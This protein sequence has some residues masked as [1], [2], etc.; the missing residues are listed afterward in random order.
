MSQELRYPSDTLHCQKDGDSTE[1]LTLR[2]TKR[3]SSY[4]DYDWTVLEVI[5]K[6][7]VTTE[8]YVVKHRPDTNS[9]S[10]KIR[11]LMK[12]SPSQLAESNVDDN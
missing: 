11:Q 7:I 5:D 9:K 4:E 12:E 3:K 10:L 1:E 2:A 6:N 8:V